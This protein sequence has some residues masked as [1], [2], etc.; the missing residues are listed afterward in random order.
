[1]LPIR[2]PALS[3]RRRSPSTDSRPT[4]TY[5]LYAGRSYYVTRTYDAHFSPAGLH[6]NR[7]DAAAC[8][9]SEPSHSVGNKYRYPED[10]LFA[11]R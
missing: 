6:G 8:L 3:I 1:M 7:F 10:R 11:S 4:R 5:E 9:R 2:I